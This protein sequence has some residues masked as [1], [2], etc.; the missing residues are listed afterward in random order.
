MSRADKDFD[1]QFYVNNYKDLQ[2]AK[3]TTEKKAYKHWKMI[4]RKEGRICAP[5]IDK[6]NINN[7]YVKVI[8]AN[9]K[10]MQD[11]KVEPVEQFPFD[12]Y[13][14]D[15][16]DDT[17]DTLE[18]AKNHHETIGNKP[19]D[20]KMALLK[21]LNISDV[22]YFYELKPFIAAYTNYSF[23]NKT[24]SEIYKEIDT[25]P[26]VGFRYFCYRYLN[27]MR[28]FIIPDIP[29]DS[30][31]EAV[32]IEFRKF[33]HL[34]FLIRNAIVKLPKDW[35]HTIVC[36]TQ[37]YDFI[38]EMCNSISD[39]IKILKYDYENLDVSKYNLLLTTSD[40]WKNLIGEKILIYQDDSCIFKSNI[41]E[42]LGYDY[43]GAPWDKKQNDNGQNVGNGGF[44]LRSKSIMLKV[45]DTISIMKTQYNSSTV[46]YMKNCNLM[47]PPEDV[48][49]SK[50]II[51]FNLGSVADYETARRFSVESVYND[52]AFGGH[53]FWLAIK[54]WKDHM[55]S[56]V[57]IQFCP[58]SNLIDILP[59]ISH[60]GGWKWV[61]YNLHKRDLYNK[62]SY[63]N[64]IDIIEHYT[65]E[66][67][68][69]TPQFINNNNKCVGFIHGTIIG[70]FDKDLCWLDIVL[71]K[72]SK[73]MFDINRFICLFT[74]SNFA[75]Q[76]IKKKLKNYGIDIPV[77]V[78][79]HPT[80]FN[81]FTN[82]DINKFITNNN[83]KLIQL[84]QQLRYHT[85][86]YKIKNDNFEKI[87][88]PG[89]DNKIKALGFVDHEMKKLG[90]QKLDLDKVKI[91]Y[92]PNYREYDELL[93]KNIIF[94]HFMD[95]NANNAIIEC[96]VRNTPLIVN[97]LPAVIEYLGT[98]YPLYFS[99]VNEIPYLLENDKIIKAY[100]YLCKMD[101][102]HLKIETFMNNLIN[103]FTH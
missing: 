41:E 49:F 26:K 57:C 48:Y 47:I 68:P 79:H 84:G 33:P 91:L 34:E 92:L 10:Q 96:I 30:N 18:K 24:M 70:R 1:W 95:A 58:P 94:M 99:D 40:F 12:L 88:L 90:I 67:L 21:E 19:F 11:K 100:E 64:L 76:Y 25:N 35:S 89:I 63:I 7:K 55:Y 82:F 29:I 39:K 71:D 13:I 22:N 3:I 42:F 52:D 51:E 50:N 61:L 103:K 27:Y 4:G 20:E 73:F 86:I 43:I 62:K 80:S 38:V 60:R 23:K 36:G 78:F 69:V 75:E 59:H 6:A 83:K 87:W 44:S 53:N 45:I 85:T 17:I 98:Q 81:T 37:N 66:K 2:R 15:I 8:K 65:F 46:N 93:D 97:N 5:S 54:N 101:K 9:I 102:S 16:T 77:Y 28:N 56:Y 74:F 32:L 72:N 31:K 14:R